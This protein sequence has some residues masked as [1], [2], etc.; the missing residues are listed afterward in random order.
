MIPPMS[1]TGRPSYKSNKTISAFFGFSVVS[2]FNI[3]CI[4]FLMNEVVFRAEEQLINIYI[5]PAD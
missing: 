2:Q 4:F 3:M 5:P 1:D